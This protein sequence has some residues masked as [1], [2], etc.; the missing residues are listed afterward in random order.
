MTRLFYSLSQNFGETFFDF[1]NFLNENNF[2]TII[3]AQNFVN[4]LIFLPPIVKVLNY[5]LRKPRNMRKANR[6][7][8][9]SNDSGCDGLCCQLLIELS[10][11]YDRKKI[12]LSILTALGLTVQRSKA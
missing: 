10:G 9:V 6:T 1:Y 5:C 12:I 11:H 4:K 8:F 3:R 7:G 2:W